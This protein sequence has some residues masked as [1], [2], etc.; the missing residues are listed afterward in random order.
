MDYGNNS[1]ELPGWRWRSHRF[2]DVGTASAGPTAGRQTLPQAG[3][4]ERLGLATRDLR[5]ADRDLRG[6]LPLLPG[7]A[8]LVRSSLHPR[9]HAD[10]RADDRLLGPRS[11][12]G[13]PD[14]SS[15]DDGDRH[16]PGRCWVGPHGDF[17]LSRRR[18]S[19]GP[20]GLCRHGTRHGAVDDPLHRGHH[21]VTAA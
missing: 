19:I 18:L 7:G 21:L 1:S 5:R 6:S 3:S 2:R 20:A 11:T 9:A 10:A 4:R 12:T 14:R 8:R 17:C 16:I 15:F 13:G